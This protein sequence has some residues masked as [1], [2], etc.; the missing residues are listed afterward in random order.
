MTQPARPDPARISS[1]NDRIRPGPAPA[2]AAG[3]ARRAAGILALHIGTRVWPGQ[4]AEFP[5]AGTA[6]RHV[7]GPAS[8]PAA[9]RGFVPGWT[10]V[11][12]V[13]S[14]VVVTAG[15]LVADA[16]QPAAY[17]PVRSTVSV[18]AGHAGTDRWIMTGALLLVGGCQLVTAA[19]LAGVRVPARIVLAVAGLSG[20][21]IAASPEPV[22]GS[23]PQH[24]AWTA[25]GA[26]AIAVW[27]AF[28]ARRAPPRPLI[29]GRFGCAV[30]TAVFMVLLG[31][32]VIET[33]GGSD[34]GL[35][36]RLTVSIETCW[37]FVVALSLRGSVGLLL[38]TSVADGAC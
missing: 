16:V 21:G 2:G 9:S 33:Q 27:P 11:S 1:A 12:A 14:P 30:V 34:L 36:E 17:N 5:V 28:V 6:R 18:M 24:V 23:T 3:P 38:R 32:L 26:V 35:A 15:W 29:L 22:R 10:V 31:W 19:G 20:I 8:P 13:L 37:P 7:R 25:L 4:L